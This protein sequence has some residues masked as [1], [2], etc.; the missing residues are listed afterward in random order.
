[1]RLW[2]LAGGLLCRRPACEPSPPGRTPLPP[3]ALW[4]TVHPSVL[5]SLPGGSGRSQVMYLIRDVLADELADSHEGLRPVLVCVPGTDLH[6]DSAAAGRL[7][8]IV[9]ATRNPRRVVTV[10]VTADTCCPQW[11]GLCLRLP[12][13]ETTLTLRG[14][15]G[16]PRCRE[17]NHTADT[18]HCAACGGTQESGLWAALLPCWPPIPVTL[19]CAH[20]AIE[21]RNPEQMA[22]VCEWPSGRALDSGPHRVLTG[23][24]RPVS[25]PL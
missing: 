5:Y 21:L 15:D 2:H 10:S 4:G 6:G 22:A 12:W 24:L 16:K 25:R 17:H 11:G 7:L 1:M 3:T 14:T 23:D 20:L 9:Q 13:P 18:Q 19:L 8:D